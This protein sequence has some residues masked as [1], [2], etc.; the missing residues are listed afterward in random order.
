ML[1]DSLLT[2]SRDVYNIQL[3]FN[4]L[5][6]NFLVEEGLGGFH[7]ELITQNEQCE[8]RDTVVSAFLR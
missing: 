1:L 4:Y 6:F 3:Y 8:V 2:C 7:M 5:N